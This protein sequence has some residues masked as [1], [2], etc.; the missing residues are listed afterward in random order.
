MRMNRGLQ[1]ILGLTKNSRIAT[2]AVVVFL[3]LPCIGTASAQSDGHVQVGAYGDYFRL[4]AAPRD[5][6]G[7]GARAGWTLY[8]GQMWG[9]KHSLAL[10]GELS[11]DFERSFTETYSRGIATS[12]S[13]SNTRALHGE[14]GPTLK[15]GNHFQ[16]FL[17]VKGGFLNVGFSTA[18]PPQ[19][20]TSALTNLRNSN[21][22]NAVLYP[23]A[24]FEWGW[25]PLGLRLDAGDLIYFNQGPQHNPSASFGPQFRF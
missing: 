20:F 9:W 2:A 17:T 24:G 15:F 3:L 1:I 4:Q 5:L 11:Y 13:P 7:V 18:T 14:F 16:P 25:G 22:G 6:L 12:F 21:N 19:G 23:G 8:H 10:E